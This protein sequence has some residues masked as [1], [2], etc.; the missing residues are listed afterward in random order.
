MA[1]TGEPIPTGQTGEAAPDSRPSQPN[2]RQVARIRDPQHGDLKRVYNPATGEMVVATKAGPENSQ[3][4]SASNT[5]GPQE[6]PIPA[7]A[8][9]RDL[10]NLGK[11]EPDHEGDRPT[12]DDYKDATAVLHWYRRFGEMLPSADT[13]GFMPTDVRQLPGDRTNIPPGIGKQFDAHGFKDQLASQGVANLR[14]LLRD[15][16][17]QGRAFH[18]VALRDTN[19]N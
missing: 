5:P 11:P 6:L 2:V 19:E 15:G 4:N 3:V 13:S 1:T 18:T 17:D 12:D 14:S 8:T 16:I 9:L 7:D 10:A